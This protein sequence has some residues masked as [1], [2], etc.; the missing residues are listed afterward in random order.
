MV[1][2]RNELAC[3][4]YED[5][6]AFAEIVSLDSG[7]SRRVLLPGRDGDGRLDLAWSPDERFLA[8]IDARNYTAQV[9]QLLVVRLED[10][11]SIPITGGMT[12]V[13]SPIWSRDGRAL[14]FISNRGGSNDLWGS[15]SMA[16]VGR[17]AL[18]AR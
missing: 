18:H 15:R 14:Y 12:N 17:A 3:V 8:Y 5:A 16:T 4:I 11:E 2:R 9:T 1:G 13:W 10:G 7:T 6:D